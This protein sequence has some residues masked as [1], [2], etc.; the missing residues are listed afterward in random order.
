M[1]NVSPIGRNCSSEERERFLLYDQKHKIREKMII[2]LKEKF[3][4]S[5]L[6]SDMLPLQLLSI[7]IFNKGKNI[8]PIFCRSSVVSSY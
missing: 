8:S 3:E 2:A 7:S 1:L 6:V 5:Y 4:L